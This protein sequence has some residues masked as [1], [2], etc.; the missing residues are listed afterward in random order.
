MVSL[1]GP[2]TIVCRIVITSRF[3]SYLLRPLF[4]SSSPTTFL[5][6]SYRYHRHI[7]FSSSHFLD[8]VGHDIFTPIPARHLKGACSYLVLISS[9]LYYYSSISSNSLFFFR[10]HS[11]YSLVSPSPFD[12]Y[13][14]DPFHRPRSPS[15]L[16][17]RSLTH[18]YGTYTGLYVVYGIL[19]QSIIN[20]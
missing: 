1:I 3:I 7:D 19:C 12:C 16:F 11:Q 10:L 5:P 20:S 14:F 6:T 2:L 4:P 18:A 17:P 8:A 13:H 9:S 15:Y